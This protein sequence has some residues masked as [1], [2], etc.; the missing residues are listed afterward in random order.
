MLFLYLPSGM[1]LQA[2]TR[3]NNVRY[4]HHAELVPG[5]RASDHQS[6]NCNYPNFDLPGRPNHFGARAVCFP[7]DGGGSPR[8]AGHKEVTAAGPR[9]RHRMSL[10]LAR[11]AVILSPKL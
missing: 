1:T 5:A 3:K 7:V 6:D 4:F 8:G 10:I 11:S 9:A 2:G